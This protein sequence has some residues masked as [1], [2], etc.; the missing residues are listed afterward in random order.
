MSA[1]PYSIGSNV[2]AGLS[3]LI[4]EM[5]EAGQ[6]VGKLIATSGETAHWAGTDLRQRPPAETADV[7]AAKREGA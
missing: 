1:G 2:W 7:A 6:A 4:E 5:G 3:K